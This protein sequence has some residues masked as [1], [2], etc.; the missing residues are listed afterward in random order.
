[1]F[2]EK[3]CSEN[4]PTS[5]AVNLLDGIVGRKIGYTFKMAS[6]LKV[7]LRNTLAENPEDCEDTRPLALP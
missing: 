2:S 3:D 1:M 4:A 5:L 6:D 7:D